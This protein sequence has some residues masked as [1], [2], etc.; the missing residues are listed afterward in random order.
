MLPNWIYYFLGK[1]SATS[2]GGSGDS[3]IILPNG[4]KFSGTTLVQMPDSFDYSQI[5]DGQ[6]F[7][8]NCSKLVEFRANME[9]LSNGRQM[10]R[11]DIK[12]QAVN[13]ETPKCSNFDN[14]FDSCSMLDTVY[15]NTSSATSLNYMFNSCTNLRTI[16]ILD[17]SK[18]RT[19]QNVFSY[20]PNLSNYSIHNI[21]IMLLQLQNYSY[22]K[23]LK[24]IG[25]N[26]TQAQTVVNIFSTEWNQ[27][28][29]LGWSTG[30]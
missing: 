27:L 24:Y 26:E 4:I 2:E 13:I 16:D 3:K 10:F 9:N 18:A 5:V 30:Y 8:Y 15:V 25:L 1:K 22:T 23:T 14:C 21:L 7:F 29:S 19:I 11:S 17:F 6:N 20:C 28:V 12:L